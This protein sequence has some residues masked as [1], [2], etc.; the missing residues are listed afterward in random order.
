MPP[1]FRSPFDLILV[2]L[3]AALLLAGCEPMEPSGHPLTPVAVGRPAPVDQST[4]V[5]E[6]DQG[7]FDFEN[8][9]RPDQEVVGDPS[10]TD[11]ELQALLLDL[12]PPDPNAP[13][14]EPTLAATPEPAPLPVAAAAATAF[15]GAAPTDAAAWGVRLLA[16]LPATQPPRAVLGLADGAEV[17]VEAGHLLPE[18]RLVVMAVGA[19]MV[20]IARIGQRGAYATVQTETL[21]PIYPAGG[22]VSP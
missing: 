18:Q 8:E 1:V 6:G 13:A 20:E 16:T 15:E 2:A 19:D 3:P 11:A 14:P 22:A 9:D 10:L 12:P 7:D 21:A 5:P 17:V 4:V